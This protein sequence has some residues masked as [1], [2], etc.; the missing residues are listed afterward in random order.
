[1]RRFLPFAALFGVALLLGCQ[2]VGTGVV[3]S[4]G[5][6]PQ[7]NKPFR[8]DKAT[9]EAQPGFIFDETTGHCHAG[10]AGDPVVDPGTLF[11]NEPFTCGGGV[12]PAGSSKGT[13][14]FNQPRGDSHMHANVQLRGAPEGDYDIFGNQELVCIIDFSNNV[15]FDL[16]PGHHTTVTVGANGKGKARIGLDFGGVPT[17]LPKIND[18]LSHAPGAHQLWVTLVGTSGDALDVVLRSTAIEVVIPEHGGVH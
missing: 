18:P 3:A 17:P 2:D 4:D 13:V 11:E 5:P 6:G 10:E 15:D 7:F 12:I 1:M 14:N 9:C 16:R 8:I